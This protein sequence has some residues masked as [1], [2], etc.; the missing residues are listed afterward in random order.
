MS[1]RVLIGMSGGVDSSV[2]AFLLK[3]QGFEVV[4]AT[5]VLWS[6][7]NSESSCCA[8]DD[9]D[10]ARHVCAT[11]GI[12][13]YVFNFKELFKE[14]VVNTFAEEYALGKTPNPCI[15]C[16]R[17]IK[18]DAF[19]HKAEELG[20]D[21]IATGHY[22]KI[23]KDDNT[24][25]FQLK[26]S[27]FIPKDQ[28]YVL[29]HV[30]Q[31]QLEHFLLPLSCY[32][33]EEIRN[34]AEKNNLVVARKPDSQDI[35]FVPD[36]NY[37]QFLKEYTGKDAKIG[38]FV[39][40]NGK[41]LGKHKGINHYTIGQ[42]KGLGIAL[43]T[44]MFVKEID[45]ETG[46]VVLVDNEKELYTTEVFA[47]DLNWISIAETNQPLKLSAKLRYSHTPSPAVVEKIND[48]TIKITF[49]TPQRAATKGQ[50]VVAYLDDAVAVGGTII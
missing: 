50:A 38:N 41:I 48:T 12:P 3:E 22:A 8:V 17:H 33:K 24:N 20:F 11:L 10:D 37:A 25:R 36:G 16:N 49:E 4:G 42:R 29:Y 23:G 13:H 1:K 35:C 28:S 32:S 31:H 40:N 34:I 46:D 44:P 18:F 26:K 30:T 14:K 43:G 7:E 21:Y 15:L 9:V 2:A 6:E 39:N 19:F 47:T 27:D 45:G 5:F